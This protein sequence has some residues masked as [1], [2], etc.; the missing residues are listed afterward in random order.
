MIGYRETIYATS[1][2]PATNAEGRMTSVMKLEGTLNR[3]K[4]LYR[5]L[6][7]RVCFPRRSLSRVSCMSQLVTAGV[8]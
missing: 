3:R 1:I 8:P 2:A 5:A 7:L 6:P 4:G